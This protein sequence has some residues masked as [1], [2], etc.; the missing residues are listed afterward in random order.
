MNVLA[1][2]GR[3]LGFTEITAEV[4]ASASSG[5]QRGIRSPWSPYGVLQQV[6]L[7]DL[8]GLAHGVTV[9][10]Q[11][12]LSLSVVNKARRVI[13]GNIGRLQLVAITGGQPA[14]VQPP[15]LAQPE[16]DRSLSE[17]LTW[18][19]DA[20]FFHPCTWWIIQSRDYYGW[21]LK[22]KLLD[23]TAAELDT[24][25]VLVRAW[26]EPVNSADVIQFNSIDSGLLTDARDIIQR[27]IIITHAASLAE[28]NPVPA[29]DIHNEG[30]RLQAE[31]IEELL[32]SWQIA[33]R[34]RGV[35]Y[36]DKMIKVNP[37]GAPTE[38]LLIE[39][40]K[41]IDLELVRACGI[42]AWAADVP[43]ETSALNYSNRASRNWE[44][45]DLALAPY[46]NAIES[47]MSMPD[48]SPA[49]WSI[50]FVADELTRD[51]AATRY[52]NYEIGLRAGFLTLPQIYKWE[53]WDA[54]SIPLQRE[55]A[56]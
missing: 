34:T 22:V 5:A 55:A 20:L 26:G 48:V 9:T 8:F 52:A 36:S 29:L 15:L 16:A 54:S 4:A 7:E 3:G 50:A 39:G 37:L 47:R 11:R 56:A 46:M 49:G 35:G 13:A 23:Q 30:D 27:G 18:T 12:A 28:D 6:T 40:R 38:Q 14:I 24:D 17:T 43:V 2:L 53:G 32:G 42:P 45:I 19:A 10:R 25:G 31:E 1:R 41:A 51:D 44:L 21:P 33:R